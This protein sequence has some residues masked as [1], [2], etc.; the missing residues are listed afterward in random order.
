[1]LKTVRHSIAVWWLVIAGAIIPAHILAAD[2]SLKAGEEHDFSMEG[3]SPGSET[4]Y[5][6][7][8]DG[9]ELPDS[10]PLVTLM[11]EE[12]GEHVITAAYSVNGCRSPET[13]ITV[14]VLESDYLPDIYPAKFF[15]PNGDGVND[16][17]EI[18]NIEYYPDAYIEIY[19]RYHKCLIKYRGADVGWDGN[20]NGH[21]MPSTD[22]W[23][24]IRDGRL[25]GGSRS[26]LF[27]LKR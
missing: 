2:I 10:T 7:T 27:I 22:Y 26:G 25:K 21:Q 9:D 12:P 14:E 11:W 3:L 4:V 24:Y 5:Y 15:T 8:V 13:S 23:Y 20:Y 16:T 19:D 6:W 18:G 1:M 17:W